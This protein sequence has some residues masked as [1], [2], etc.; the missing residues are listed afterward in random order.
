MQIP[1]DELRSGITP[2]IDIDDLCRLHQNPDLKS[3]V[4]VVDM[5]S[6]EHLATFGPISGA[7]VGFVAKN[8]IRESLP[9]NYHIIVIVND[10]ALADTLVRENIPHVCSLVCNDMIPKELQT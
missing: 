7:N 5:R 6:A 9:Q 4:F 10:T 1:L 8:Y 3:R 2:R